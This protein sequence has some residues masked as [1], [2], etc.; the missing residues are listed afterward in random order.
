MAPLTP[1]LS[2]IRDLFRRRR[3]DLTLDEELRAHI[4]MLADDYVR[5]G[6]T[7]DEARRK[8]RLR[9]GGVEQT[10]EAARDARGTFLDSVS[11]GDDAI[12]GEPA[13][14]GATDRAARLPDRRR[15][16]GHRCGAGLLPGCFAVF[17]FR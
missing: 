9:L 7:P 11:A 5:G 4:E 3:F 14:P 2:R 17:S 1:F 15:R 10:K 6:M 8:A 13:V 16:V 12:A